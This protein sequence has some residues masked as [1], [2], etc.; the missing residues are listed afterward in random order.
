MSNNKVKKD[1][2]V[3]KSEKDILTG[4]LEDNHAYTLTIGIPGKGK[5]KIKIAFEKEV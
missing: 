4:T 3:I 2:K 1:N 5:L